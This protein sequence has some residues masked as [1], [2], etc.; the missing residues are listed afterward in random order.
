MRKIIHSLIALLLCNAA[1]A[2]TPG[3][4]EPV[5][6]TELMS[7]YKKAAD[8]FVKTSNYQL[9]VHYASFTDYTTRVAYDQSEGSYIRYGANVNNHAFGMTTI[10][11][12][13]FRFMVDSANQVIVLNNASP[14]SQ[15]PV[16]DKSFS[17]LLD[18]VQS[19][20]K[21]AIAGGST[22]YRIEFRPNDLYTASEFVINEK[23]QL[24]KLCYYY[25]KA[26]S[27]EDDQGDDA[28]NRP[29]TKTKPRMEVMFSGY[30][31]P[32]H[33]DQQIFSE[34][35]YFRIEKNRIIPS[36]RYKNYTIRD[37]RLSAN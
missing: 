29:V 19:M 4:W 15:S 11:N 37:Y 35:K 16:D 31:E 27:E 1:V 33:V 32:G 14:V 9:S 21:L 36:E 2:G 10:Q 25:S 22:L 17:D 23:G 12:A 7:A 8:W 6:K 24:G 3:A 18:H 5:A 34:K 13:T 26:M 20:K 30:R 28:A